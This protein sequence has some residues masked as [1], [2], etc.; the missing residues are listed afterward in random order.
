[1]NKIIIFCKLNEIYIV[2]SF[3]PRLSSVLFSEVL[4]ND[5]FHNKISSI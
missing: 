1:M 2:R 4:E 3:F 5:F